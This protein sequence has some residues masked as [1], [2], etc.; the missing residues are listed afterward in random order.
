[1]FYSQVVRRPSD[2]CVYNPW[3][4]MFHEQQDLP[5]PSGEFF[6]P[7]T[8]RGRVNENP[9]VPEFIKNTQ[10]L[11]VANFSRSAVRGNCRG[12]TKKDPI[13]VENTPLEKRTYKH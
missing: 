11:R 7:A 1:M 13:D 12:A 9:N 8:P 2:L 6:R 4:E 5:R 10:A 3:G